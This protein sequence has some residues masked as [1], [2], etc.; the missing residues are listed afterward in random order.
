MILAIL[1]VVGLT[2]GLAIGL[3]LG[4]VVWPVQYYDTDIADLQAEYKEQYII[5]IGE[6]YILDRDLE[7]AQA[8]LEELEVPSTSQWIAQ[9]A[10]RY[11][12]E[13]RDRAGDPG[14]GR[15]G[16]RA[17]CRHTPDGCFPRQPNSRP[18]RHPA[19]DA[20]AHSHPTTHAN[21]HS[22]D[23]DPSPAVADVTTIGNTPTHQH[24]RT[25]SHRYPCATNRHIP[26]DLSTP[27]DEPA[28]NEPAT[29][30]AYQHTQ[31]S[32]CRLDLDG[33]LGRARPG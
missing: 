8:R 16:P 33:S 14:A 30:T 2:V 6:A 17:G 27:A 7:K 26:A 13:G 22:A 10:D 32:A 29:A 31:A 24:A 4:W 28:T 1:I 23:R 25:R 21:F 9:L 5:L 19:A 3:L 20:D 15:A 11:I 18:H 12:A